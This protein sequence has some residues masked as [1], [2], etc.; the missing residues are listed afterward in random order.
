MRVKE[1]I[2]KKGKHRSGIYFRPH[3]NCKSLDC[4]VTFNS[5]CIYD[6]GNVNQFDINKLIGVSYG[7]HHKNSA[8]FGW[9]AVGDQIKLWA[10]CYIDS[11]RVFT[12]LGKIDVEKQ[13]NLKLTVTDNSYIFSVFDEDSMI[14]HTLINKSTTISFGYFLFPYF[15][16]DEVAPHLMSL[17]LSR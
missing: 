15:G 3:L 5:N 1:F 4:N 7:L 11:K 10:Y 9:N 8:R 17:K 12:S 6:L 2:I 16:G 14:G 13:Y